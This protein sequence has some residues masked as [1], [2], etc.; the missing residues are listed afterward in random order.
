VRVG[1]VGLGALGSAAAWSLAGAGVDVVGFE[2]FPLG[3]DRGASHDHSRIIRRSYHTPGYVELAGQA[4]EAWARLEAETG[5]TCVVRTG[6][7]DL[8]P[9]GGAIPIEDYTRSLAACAVPFEVLDAAAA[10]R[11]WPAWRLDPD[12]TVLAQADTGIVAAERAGR[13]LRDAAVARGAQ[14]RAECA[15]AA[16][17]PAGGEAGDAVRIVSD[18]GVDVVDA[19]VVAADA[20]TNEVLVGFEA[21]V[22]LTVT[23][24]QLTYTEPDD[25]ER[26]DADRFPVWIWMD[27]PSWYGFP[28]FGVTGMVKTA[29][30]CGGR[31]VTARTRTDAPDPAR[32]AA[33]RAFLAARVPGADTGRTVSKTCLYTL[34]PD[35]DFVLDAVPGHPNVI[36]ALGAAHGFKFAARIGEI[37]ADLVV[38]RPVA[39]DLTP[40]AFTRPAL[41]TPTPDRR[42]LV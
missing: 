13:A 29:E 32:E 6:G 39:T 4:Y 11:R 12:V 18:A 41:T 30:D 1:V 9:A 15:V 42:W 23:Q 2:Q 19:V 36:V 31:E 10:M 7:I 27:D 20:W 33:L 24:E 38:G 34:T 25:V 40:F 8:F 5:V 28:E 14:L 35:R 37:A 26:F 21:S 22:P 17:E 16:V 3:H